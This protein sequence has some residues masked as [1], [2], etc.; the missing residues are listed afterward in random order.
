MN[1]TYLHDLR[2]ADIEAGARDTQKLPVELTEPEVQAKQREATRLTIELATAEA[3]VDAEKERAKS[4]VKSAEGKVTA[5]KEAA[6][7]LARE[8]VA[9]EEYRAVETR[10]IVDRRVRKVFVARIDT[11][12]I[13]TQRPATPLELEKDC[14]ELMSDDGRWM[15]LIHT[16]TGDIVRERM[17]TAAE[18][19]LSLDA[20]APR[21]I[22]WVAKAQWT[23]M[24]HDDVEDL[25]KPVAHAAALAWV[26]S[27]DWMTAH[28]PR[29]AVLEAVMH[30]LGVLEIGFKVGNDAPVTLGDLSGAKGASTEKVT[31]IKGKRAARAEK[32]G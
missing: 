23:H 1:I 22:V 7:Q 3:A 2:D 9:R 8:A 20:V 27:G 17:T 6:R 25:T 15:R 28:I 21:E 14:E 24:G 13:L 16:A 18:R 5:I 19:Q 30:R 31:Q 12:E 32:A 29:G 4:W 10:E 26:E 11:G